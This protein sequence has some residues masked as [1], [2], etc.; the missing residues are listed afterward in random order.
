ML[1]GWVLFCGKQGDKMIGITKMNQAAIQ[2]RVQGGSN[3][4]QVVG[5]V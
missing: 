3:N 1:R 5:R 2:R 4:G